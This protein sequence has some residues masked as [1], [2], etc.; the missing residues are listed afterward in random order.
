M[1]FGKRVPNHISLNSIRIAMRV[2]FQTEALDFLM[3]PR[4][5][6]PKDIN[7]QIHKTIPYQ[8][9]FIAG[10]EFAHYILGH[11]SDKNLIEKPILKAIFSN[12][13]DY[14]NQKV[15][16]YS[17][18][19]EF[20]ADI[21]SIEL[22]NYNKIEKERV[23]ESAL[24]WFAG[25][26]LYEAIVGYISPPN[27]YL[28]HPPARARYE[29]LLEKIPMQKNY[30]YSKWKNLMKLIDNLNHFFTDEIECNIERYETFGSCYLDKPNTE[31]RGRELVDRVDYY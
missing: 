15:Y 14:G 7:E 12:Q 27:S 22:G 19:N 1:D 13:S 17:Q 5:I 24:I 6:I 20:D 11:I 25:L 31:W 2:M 4:G 26:D 3:D 10:H 21:M 18:K 30:D 16:N 28:T 23:F 9:Q 8:M 29:N